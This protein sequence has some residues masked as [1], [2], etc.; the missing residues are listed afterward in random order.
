M[1]SAPDCSLLPPGPHK[2]QSPANTTSHPSVGPDG[3]TANGASEIS[4]TRTGADIANPVIIQNRT[5]D[6]KLTPRGTGSKVD[7]IDLD[8]KEQSTIARDKP[9]TSHARDTTSTSNSMGATDCI[10]PKDMPPLGSSP[11]HPI[12]INDH[13][14]A[15]EQD[16]MASDGKSDLDDL[17]MTYV[18]KESHLDYDTA[19]ASIEGDLGT[20]S[21]GNKG[22]H[23]IK[24]KRLLRS[25]ESR[26]NKARKTTK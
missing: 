6:V 18:R 11:H 1:C 10:T 9:A 7:P 4:S 17:D 8:V 20:R 26:A 15:Y 14:Q 12:W 21:K 3:P 5:V 23:G 22:G 2:S 24:R 16:S 19:V 13:S 25:A